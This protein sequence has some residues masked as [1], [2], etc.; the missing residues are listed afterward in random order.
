M[1]RDRT[2]RSGLFFVVGSG[3]PVSELGTSFADFFVGNF[4]ILKKRVTFAHAYDT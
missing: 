2:Y 1:R 4:G 3:V